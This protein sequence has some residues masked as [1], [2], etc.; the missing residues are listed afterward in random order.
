V[1]GSGGTRT[2]SV[3][4]CLLD[5]VSKDVVSPL[6]H[7]CVVSVIFDMSG[8]SWSSR[9]RPRP[10]TSAKSQ[11]CSCRRMPIILQDQSSKRH[12]R[13]GSKQPSLHI[14]CHN[15]AAIFAKFSGEE[16][17]LRLRVFRLLTVRRDL[18]CEHAIRGCGLEP[19]VW[20]TSEHT[21]RCQHQGITLCDAVSDSIALLRR[22]MIN[23]MFPTAA[24]SSATTSSCL[25]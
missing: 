7:R 8:Q 1:R 10:S 21:D 9:P 24:F 2:A 23:L 5:I 15:P 17:R 3:M 18:T 14:S 12:L 13:Y 22:S 16:M 20:Q 6:L 4:Y 25:T 19:Q 11:S